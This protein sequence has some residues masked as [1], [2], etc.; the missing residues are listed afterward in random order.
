MNSA[1]GNEITGS[2][3]SSKKRSMKRIA[4]SS[5]SSSSTDNTTK[6]EDE[7]KKARVGH[8]T[9]II[10]NEQKNSKIWLNNKFVVR[11]NYVTSYGILL[12]RESTVSD[13]TSKKNIENTHEDTEGSSSNNSSGGVVQGRRFE[14]LLGMIPQGNS[15]TVFKGLPESDERPEETA[16]R[17]FEEETSLPFPYQ[18]DEW[19]KS[20]CPVKSELYGVTSTKK[21]LQIFLIPAPPGLDV[22]KFDVDEVVK[23]DG[24]GRFS[25]LPEIVE[26]RFLTKKQAIE[27]I[28]SKGKHKIAKIYKS[29]VSI[30]ERADR[31]LNT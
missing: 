1:F 18:R 22:S 11:P 20:G 21:L 6:N 4:S 14:Y 8:C 25:G 30:L 17:E 23:I 9:N 2:G 26:I 13:E 16:V 7:N 5:S 24:S 15:W 27:G 31:I 12:Y 3:S 10:K 28:R 19:G 29:Q